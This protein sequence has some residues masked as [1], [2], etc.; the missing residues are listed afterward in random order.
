MPTA[1]TLD[2]VISAKD[3]ASAKVA[4][5]SKSIKTLGITFA[6]VGGA[7]TAG[8]GF[9]VKAA[10]DAQKQ[11]AQF[12]AIVGTLGDAA[13]KADMSLADLRQE[14]IDAGS[15]ATKLGF[16][17]E[18]VTLAVARLTK[19]TGDA[20]VGMRG[21]S[22]AMDLARAKNIDLETATYAVNMSLQGMPKLLRQYGIELEDTA[23]KT[24]ILDALTTSFG[25]TAEKMTSTFSVQMEA[26]QEQFKNFQEDIGAILIPILIDVLKAIKPVIEAI[27]AWSQAHPELTKWIVILGAGLGVLLTVVGG[28]I[29]IMPTITAL[30]TAFGVVLAFVAAN[31]IVLIIAGIIALVAAIVWIIYNWDLVKQKT[32]E[33]WSWIKDFLAANWEYIVILLTG[34]VGLLAIAIIKNWENIKAAT[35][36]IWD[37]IRG[38]IQEVVSWI[39]AKVQVAINAYNSAAALLATP[40]TTVTGAIGGAAGKVGKVLGFQQ[41][42]IITR[43]TIGMLGEKGAEAVVPLNRAGAIGNTY[44]VFVN[45]NTIFASDAD[46][47]AMVIG[48]A[49]IRRL[50]LQMRI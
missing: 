6:A 9:A 17:N 31:P 41:G 28:L 34:G 30:V 18:A 40:L 16:D 33:V 11:M 5:I 13:K 20:E 27:V 29:L 4:D 25:G 37:A 3:E 45:G 2:I 44:N 1:A 22:L 24:E 50:N 35:F 7:I 47:A 43:P 26:A 46:E 32:L 19:T 36:A 48:D 12:D 39:E 38:K 23:T 49:L 14:M 8:F 21:A 42:G 15:V 10:A